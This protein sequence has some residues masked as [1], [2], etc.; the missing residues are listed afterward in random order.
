MTQAEALTILKTGANVFLT[1]E[2]GAGKSYT[3]NQYVT[4]LKEHGI[5]HAIT[6]S[7][8]IAATHIGGMTIHSWSGLGIRDTL[9]AYDLEMLTQKEY[10]AKRI[11]KTNVLIIDEISMLSDTMLSTINLVCKAVRGKD[12]PFGGLQAVFVGDF[13]QLPPVQ[14]RAP[15]HQNDMFGSDDPMDPSELPTHFAFQSTAWSDAAPIIC[16]LSEQHRQSDDDLLQILSTLRNGER[17]FEAHEFLTERI[18]KDRTR[19]PAVTKLYSHNADVDTL[20][21]GELTKLPGL[22]KKF[23]MTTAGNQVLIENLKKGCLSPEVLELKVGAK[24]MFTKNNPTEGYMNGTLGEVI[25]F[26]NSMPLVKT[27]GGALITVE[28]MEWSVEEDGKVKAR[29]AQ[30]PLRLAWAITIHKSQGMSL[31]GAIMDLS[32]VFEYGQGYVA[33]SRVRTLKGIHLLGFNERALEVHPRVLMQDG[34]FR[35]ASDVAEDMFGKMTN[36]DLA[37]MHTNFIIACGG[38]LKKRTIADDPFVTTN[39]VSTYTLT[40]DLIN[41]GF[42]I[43][44]ILKKRDMVF[45]TIITHLETIKNNPDEYPLKRSLEGLFDKKQLKYVAEIH[46]IVEKLGNP[47]TLKSIYDSAGGKYSY[48]DIKVARLLYKK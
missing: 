33:L 26:K 13:F 17:L 23:Q 28:E 1:G 21:G 37:K 38:S 9:S 8:G 20:N 41:E 2:P 46:K 6:A 44:E 40:L 32:R 18:H 39:K 34:M 30:V 24:V 43:A 47:E 7:T 15:I 19:L 16:Y 45:G 29:L 10:V 36:E 25:D 5:N 11:Q 14:R 35:D 22:V 12:E 42:S 31:D 48:D 3:I 27:H 4:Y